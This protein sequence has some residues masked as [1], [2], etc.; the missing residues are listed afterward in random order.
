MMVA[1]YALNR[2]MTRGNGGRTPYELWVGNTSIVHH[3]RTFECVVHVKTTGYLKKLDDHSKP[4]IFGGYAPG[5]KAYQA[6]DP[7]TTR[8]HHA[9]RSV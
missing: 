5:S 3:M 1:V 2:T 6:Y 4:V 7:K 8:Q 9:R